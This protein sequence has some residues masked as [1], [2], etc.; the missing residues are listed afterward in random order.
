MTRFFLAGILLLVSD[1][2]GVDQRGAPP[3][4]LELLPEAL[5]QELGAQCLDHSPAGYYVREQ[6]PDR[7]VIF[8]QGGFLCAEPI[9]CIV[10]AQT[11]LGS[12]KYWDAA[13]PPGPGGTTNPS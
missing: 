7:W 8:L 5:A 12:S 11:A 2:V 6:D 4:R 10:R 9:D 3:M 13:A 1:A